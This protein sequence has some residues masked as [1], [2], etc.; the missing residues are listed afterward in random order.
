MLAQADIR[1]LT[2][3]EQLC[4]EMPESMAFPCADGARKMDGL[5]IIR[6]R[7]EYFWIIRS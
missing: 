4:C 3:I 7:R 1:R 5:K 2:D 6:I